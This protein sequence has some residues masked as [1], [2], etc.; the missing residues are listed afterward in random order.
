VYPR[1][2]LGP[3][4]IHSYGLM[5][6]LGLGVGIG[7]LCWEL[8]RKRLDPSHGLWIALIA[9]PAG[10]VGARLLFLAEEWALFLLDP[11][12]VALS[13]GGLSFYGGFLL[14]V[15]AIHPYLRWSR[16]G[17][18]TFGDAAAPGALLG[19]GLGRI[20]CHLA[21]DGDYG[22]PTSLPWGTDY[23]RGVYP[24][25]AALK[26][27]PE[28]TAAFPGGVAPADIRLHPT[29]MYEFLL[30]AL[31]FAVLWTF[32]RR[33]APDG[34]MLMLYFLAAGSVRFVI[35]FLALAHPMAFG[36]TEAQL[37][38]LGLIVIGAAGLAWQAM[39][40]TPPAPV[41]RRR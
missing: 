2:A 6:A 24:P 32:R 7:L 30:C 31:L 25:S 21:G 34:R 12:R 1:I 15:A 10:V 27:F 13:G 26:P 14:A 16:I 11:T 8:R 20:G 38:S 28:I 33:L 17:W 29:G 37:F 23:S 40:R 5:L 36:L 18:L 22:V 35:E 19:R 3:V 4:V 9:I 41:V 39:H